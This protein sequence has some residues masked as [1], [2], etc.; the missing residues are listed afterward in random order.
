MPPGFREALF[1]S[2]VW[3][4][5]PLCVMLPA[6]ILT[7]QVQGLGE[8]ASF[9]TGYATSLGLVMLLHPLVLLV[10]GRSILVAAPAVAAGVTVAAVLQTAADY[11]GQRLL[12]ELFAGH[13]QPDASPQALL[14]VGTVYWALDACNVALWW[15]S[16]AARRMR[17]AQVEMAELQ[18]TALRA[19]LNMLRLQLNPHFMCNSLNAVS[20][21]ILGGRSADAAGMAE[22]LADFLRS[23]MELRG[24]ETRLREEFDLVDAYL[25]VEAV[26][27]GDRLSVEVDLAPDAVDASVPNFIVQ[28]LVE[29]A[30][31]HGVERIAG[32]ATLRVVA[33]REDG[34]VAILVENESA[35]PS[36]PE[37]PA[38]EGHGIGL[39]NTRARLAML[40]GDGAALETEALDRGYRATIRLPYRAAA[41]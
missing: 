35:Q 2:A 21:L 11:G 14:V 27:F 3:W 13:R 41:R 20:S 25:A 15:M 17:V 31:K 30:L 39:A 5:A 34:E 12:H 40:F 36:A 8:L 33:R 28:P 10:T 6:S 29:N 18:N 16:S 23:T 38:R 9:V 26:R 7:G 37:T 19:E 4:L 32:P 1:L 22:R 24:L